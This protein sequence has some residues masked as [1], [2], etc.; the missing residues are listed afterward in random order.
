VGR[1]LTFV[2]ADRERW[3]PASRARKPL[4]ARSADW[5]V[6]G[7]RSTWTLDIRFGRVMCSRVASFMAA[8]VGRFAVSEIPASSGCCTR[9]GS[10]VET[11][12]GRMGGGKLKPCCQFSRADW[13][14]SACLR[15]ARGTSRSTYRRGCDGA[16]ASTRADVG[17]SSRH[18]ALRLSN[19]A[20]ERTVI[21]GSAAQASAFA[22]HADA[23][24]TT[25]PC[26][27]AAQLWR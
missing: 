25:W 24:H 11:V 20:L 14:S 12:S 15:L 23:G 2:G 18:F 7:G 17:P 9:S 6:L 10:Q 19:F 26:W 1:V 22:S 27:A 21:L 3:V 4:C 16:A 8:S 5:A 13:G